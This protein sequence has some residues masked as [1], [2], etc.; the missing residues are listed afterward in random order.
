MQWSALN[1]PPVWDWF[2]ESLVKEAKRLGRD[3][4]S[5]EKKRAKTDDLAGVVADLG[6]D[7]TAY[8]RASIDALDGE[9][10][11]RDELVVFLTAREQAGD[12]IRRRA[13]GRQYA[14]CRRS[15]R[16]QRGESGIPVATP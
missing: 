3:V 9:L 4:A 16:W 13:E 2:P 8:L 11:L 7:R 12:E 6:N 5:V 1:A 15:R 14:P 10:Q